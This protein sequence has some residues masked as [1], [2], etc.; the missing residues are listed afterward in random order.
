[1]ILSLTLA[2]AASGFL[3]FNFGKAKI[4]MGDNGPTFIGVILTYFSLLLFQPETTA[5]WGGQKTLLIFGGIQIVPL[6]DMV[7]VILGRLLHGKSPLRGDRTH[8][9]HLLQATGLRSSMICW[10][11]YKWSVIVSV[12]VI[13]WLPENVYFAFPIF[14]IAAA[15]PYFLVAL[16]QSILRSKSR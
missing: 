13:F 11:L 2:G 10:L 6:T 12:C 15:I 3:V 1:M 14:I 7:K 16:T 8:I 4:F 9:H 5:F